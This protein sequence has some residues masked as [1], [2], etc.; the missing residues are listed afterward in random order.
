[1]N[2]VA[3]AMAFVLAFLLLALGFADSALFVQAAV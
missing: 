2:K 3:F 1:V